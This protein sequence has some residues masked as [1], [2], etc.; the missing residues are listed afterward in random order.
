MLNVLI[1]YAFIIQKY[2]ILF[3]ILTMKQ[4]KLNIYKI[5]EWNNMIGYDDDHTYTFFGGVATL[6]V[7]FLFYSI[8]LRIYSFP[9]TFFNQFYNKFS[10]ISLWRIQW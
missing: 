1:K 3:C 8:F 6:L 9:T 2:K 4:N 5:I 7:W 10:S